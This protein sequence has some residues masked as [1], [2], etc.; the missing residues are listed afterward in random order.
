MVA[1]QEIYK[2]TGDKSYID[3]LLQNGSWTQTKNAPVGAK[4]MPTRK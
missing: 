4:P 2:K 1:T 3:K